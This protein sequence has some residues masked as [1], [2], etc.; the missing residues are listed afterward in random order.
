MCYFMAF[1]RI[2]MAASKMC[3]TILLFSHQGQFNFV[4][5]I[6]TPLDYDCNLVT[7]QCRKG[8]NPSSLCSQSFLYWW[9]SNCLHFSVFLCFKSKNFQEKLSNQFAV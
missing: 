1:T 8:R 5:V 3:M 2:T 6:I 9:C 4:H 7:L